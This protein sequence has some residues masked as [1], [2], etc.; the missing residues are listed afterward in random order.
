MNLAV[1]ILLFQAAWFACV[2][3][4]AKGYP[5]AGPVA[6]CI[7]AIVRTA[8]SPYRGREA[9]LLV[10][11]GLLGFAADSALIGLG[12][13]E[14]A[15]GSF[16]VPWSPPW[17]VAMWVNFGATLNVSLAFL[18]NRP[19]LSAALGALGG[20]MAYYAGVRLGAA[21]IPEPAWAGLAAI[22]AAWGAA[23]PLM[24]GLA[25]RLSQASPPLRNR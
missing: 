24:A 21:S 20:P 3:G 16:P 9:F 5:W 7:A 12:F 10:S 25:T 4:A 13:F 22:G 18:K 6:V 15:R 17:L 1:N 19:A 14:P 11:C 23:L 2:L 8:Q